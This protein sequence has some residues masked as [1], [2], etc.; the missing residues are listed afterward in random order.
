MFKYFALVFLTVS[1]L[2]LSTFPNTAQNS[3][4]SPIQSG[5]PT[6]FVLG[7][8]EDEYEKLIMAH[9]TM[10]LAA[11]DYDMLVAHEKWLSMLT[12]MEAYAVQIDY[13]L[14]GLKFW[15]HV[16]WNA[17]GTINHIGFHLKPQ[18]RNVDDD[19]LKAFL[20]SFSNNYQFPH[21]YAGKFAHYGSTAFPTMPVILGG[22]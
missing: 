12:E 9:E 20:T 17:N 4:V 18:S 5:L 6:V 2:M 13:N 22:N 14:N 7:D 1:I 19:E 8:Q 10:L 11:C 15:F 21:T 16:F 3:S